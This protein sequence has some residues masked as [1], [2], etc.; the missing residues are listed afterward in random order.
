[1]TTSTERA[2]ST[3][4][5]VEQSPD[6]VFAAVV[7]VRAWWTGEIEGS[8]GEQGAEFTYRH[9]PQHYSR[10][11]VTE[12]EPGRRVVWRVVDSHLSFVSE[13]AEWTGSDITFD[14]A[15]VDGGTE[16]RFTHVG[17][18]PDVECF[19]ACSTAWLHYV[20][21]SLHSLI[22]TGQGLPDPW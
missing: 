11:R 1:M 16:L 9:P 8:A 17:L 10:Q 22:T 14:I 12:F 4:F 2:Y 7:D 13:P 3:S 20:N 5:T 15:A 21:G 6:E 18:V 19:G